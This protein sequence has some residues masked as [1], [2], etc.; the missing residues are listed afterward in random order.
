MRVVK[1][2]FALTGLV[3]YPDA[4]HVE[5]SEHHEKL[6]EPACGHSKLGHDGLAHVTLGT[7]L[8]RLMS[9]QEFF[10]KYIHPL[11]GIE[12]SI[13]IHSRPLEDQITLKTHVGVSSTYSLVSYVYIFRSSERK[14][15]RRK[16]CQRRS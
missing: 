7:S 14:R 4:E 1:G 10:C 13:F 2:R 6:R 12:I 9:S 15:G 3:L 16:R 8:W 5:A 11:S